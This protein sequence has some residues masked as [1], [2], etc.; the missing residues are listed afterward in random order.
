MTSSP[1]T[2]SASYIEGNPFIIRFKTVPSS[3]NWSLLLNIE[4]NPFIIRFKTDS[5][6]KNGATCIIDIEG[7]PFIIRFKTYKSYERN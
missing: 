6:V 7:N 1:T 3:L 5:A 2:I 4:G